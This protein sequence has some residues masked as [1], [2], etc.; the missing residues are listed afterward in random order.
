[1]SLNS[2]NTNSGAYIALESL[3]ATNAQLTVTQNR[4]SSGLKVAS[5]KDNAALYA[6]AQNERSQVT[7]LDSVKD[8]LNRGQ[9]VADTAS[10]AGQ[11][12]SDLVTQLKAKALAYSDTSNSTA[13]QA[14]YAQEYASL[15]A[16]IATTV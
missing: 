10:A 2:V 15:Y 11:A 13:D 1:M 4:V 3:N 5:A 12:V 6:I 16:Q 9:S 14:A 7:A 8:S